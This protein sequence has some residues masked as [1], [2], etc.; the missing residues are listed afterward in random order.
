[1]AD[2]SRNM[3][4]IL[5]YST[6][7]LV[8]PMVL[9]PELLGTELLR[10]S[11]INLFFEIT[12][13]G[14]VLWFF[15]REWPMVQLAGAVGLC[16]IYRLILGAI[17]GLLI[18]GLHLLDLR[19]SIQLGMSSYLPAILLHGLSAPFILMSLLRH[20]YARPQRRM[21]P[22]TGTS[23]QMGAVIHAV[24]YGSAHATPRTPE[25]ASVRTESQAVSHESAM[26]FGGHGLNGFDRATRYI[27]E[28]N[29]VTLAAVVD[30]EG[31]L[32]SHFVRGGVDAE[33]AAPYAIQFMESN[34]RILERG[35]W[36]SPDRLDM[37]MKDWRVVICREQS[38]ALM[39][40]AERHG[41]DLLAIRVNQGLE[42]I[43]KY[44]AERYSQKPAVNPERSYVPST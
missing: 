42:L 20:S 23:P 11:L 3:I 14:G 4:Q 6:L 26:P 19:V 36:G 10:P 16:A 17:F 37:T 43:R 15:N 8:V 7:A 27:G 39:V 22:Q 5:L 21:M 28:L 32:M 40:I 1:M 38:I 12:F 29:A 25:V 31:L 13:Y 44:Y 33:M 18:S 24:A 30:H 2:N 41:D 35:A 9:F 34:K